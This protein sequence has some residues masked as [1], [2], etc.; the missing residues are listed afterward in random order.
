M[1]IFT[2]TTDQ[3]WIRE[4]WLRVTPQSCGG[5]YNWIFGCFFCL[6]ENRKPFSLKETF[7]GQL[8]LSFNRPDHRL[9]WDPHGDRAYYLGPALTHYRC[10]R[11]YIVST[12]S[13]RITLTLAHFPLPYLAICTTKI[14]SLHF[15]FI[16]I[17]VVADVDGSF[18]NPLWKEA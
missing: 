4:K 3:N 5:G 1:I 11:V 2:F 15:I 16:P 8:C 12:R 17:A 14:A 7:S 6:Q 13:E 9:S 18:S 10:H